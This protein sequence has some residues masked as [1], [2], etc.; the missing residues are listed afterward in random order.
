MKLYARQKGIYNDYRGRSGSYE[1]NEEILCTP[2]YGEVLIRDGLASRTPDAI[3]L[4]NETNASAMILPAQPLTTTQISD[5]GSMAD[6][7]DISGVT[8]QAL[9]NLIESGYTSMESLKNL[10]ANQVMQLA[11]VNRATAK[12]IVAFVNV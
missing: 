2:E 6:L 4:P 1:V 10:S 11:Q 3:V 5:L 12:K 7:L 9:I 8:Q